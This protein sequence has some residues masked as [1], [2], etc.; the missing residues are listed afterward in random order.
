[1]PRCLTGAAR[2]TNASF[3]EVIVQ[4]TCVFPPS[5][6]PRT[7]LGR[8]HAKTQTREQ[9][10]ELPDP[11]GCSAPAILTPPPRVIVKRGPVR[12]Q[13]RSRVAQFLCLASA[14]RI[15]GRRQAGFLQPH[16]RSRL[17]A[18]S[19]ADVDADLQGLVAGPRIAPSESHSQSTITR[20][21]HVRVEGDAAAASTRERCRES[22]VEVTVT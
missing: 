14:R 6:H 13:L 5:Q 3:G 2:I 7:R 21:A 17:R 19:T 18:R 1:M 4:R 8:F 20:P 15:R 12:A 11:V 22:L 10:C 9:R 16:L